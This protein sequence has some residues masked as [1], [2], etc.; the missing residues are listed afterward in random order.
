MGRLFGKDETPPGWGQGK[1]PQ[2]YLG[3]EWVE[4]DKR[5]SV[6]ETFECL[7]DRDGL[8]YIKNT[9]KPE[10]V[11]GA[12][13]FSTPSVGELENMVRNLKI[14][15]SKP[16][17]IKFL[18][19]PIEGHHRD[20]KYENA[21]F[22]AASQFNCLEFIGDKTIPEQGI[23]KYQTDHTQG[24]ACCMAA[25][26]GTMYRNYF[27]K[28]GNSKEVGQ[29]AERQINN[30]ED[31]LEVLG[32]E[33]TVQVKGGHTRSAHE[34]EM[35]TILNGISN[36]QRNKAI[37]ALKVGIH[38]DVEVT[39]PTPEN[40]ELWKPYGYTVNQVFV[41]ACSLD[42]CQDENNWKL[43]AEMVLYG[44]YL[45]TLFS[46][47][48]NAHRCKDDGSNTVFLTDLGGGAFR[49]HHSWIKSARNAALE[50]PLVKKSGLKV[51]ISI[52]D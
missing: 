4:G 42:Q 24:P 46:A 13:K 27:V 29:T 9:E 44:S 25:G 50:H 28:V 47:I 11:I 22:Q 17:E 31:T 40:S 51:I 41:S 48:I 33:N 8:N 43:L 20:R 6:Y 36:E 14:S 7:Q 26:G 45:A 39:G 32:L 16:C 15:N 30:I 1:R 10:I 21:T 37:A 52:Y 5:N 19:G 34:E 23:G 2:D 3:T 18:S 38:N 12:G 35:S 49:N